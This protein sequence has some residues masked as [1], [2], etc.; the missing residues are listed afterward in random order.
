M[1]HIGMQIIIC[2]FRYPG[3]VILHFITMQKHSID[4][5][6]TKREVLSGIVGAVVVFA[7][8]YILL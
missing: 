7:A 4:F 5:F 3:A 2:V 6:L 1:E 8:I